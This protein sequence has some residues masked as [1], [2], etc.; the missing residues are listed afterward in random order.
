MSESEQKMNKS[1]GGNSSIL[2]NA[3]LRDLSG[4][5]SRLLP[6]KELRADARAKIEQTMKQALREL[7]IL[8][9]EDF[10]IQTETLTKAQE[11]VEEL[12]VQVK[13]LEGRLETL[14]AGKSKSKKA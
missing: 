14:E 12:E 8:T 1:E 7:D 5:V 4:R 2:N 13:D 3:F 6:A 10:K 9:M 11:R